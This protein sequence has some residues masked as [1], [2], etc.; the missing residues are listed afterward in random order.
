MIN[1]GHCGSSCM[2]MSARCG[3]VCVCE[4]L[5]MHVCMCACVHECLCA[6]VHVCKCACAHVCMRACV[7]VYKCARVHVCMCACVHVCIIN[8]YLHLCIDSC[9]VGRYN[10]SLLPHGDQLLIA[11][12]LSNCANKSVVN[13]RR[14][15]GV[16]TIKYATVLCVQFLCT[17]LLRVS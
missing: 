1:V 17:C 2:C 11:L 7:R 10:T 8:L 9:C 4:R 5:C 6:Y 13:G 14:V 12:L 15:R 3:C 16:R